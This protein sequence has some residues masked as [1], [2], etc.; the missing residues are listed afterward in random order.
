MT[1]FRNGYPTDPTGVPDGK[2][3]TIKEFAEK[4]DVDENLV[5]VWIKR[6]QVSVEYFYGR[7]YIPENAVVRFK[8]KKNL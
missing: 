2:Y 4:L 5:R 6:R 3:Y 1:E 7:V 8:H